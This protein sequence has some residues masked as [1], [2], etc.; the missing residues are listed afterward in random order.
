MPNNVT[1]IN[2]W[3]TSNEKHRLF[4]YSYFEKISDQWLGRALERCCYHFAS[5]F[6]PLQHQH[7]SRLTATGIFVHFIYAVNHLLQ[8]RPDCRGLI[9]VLAVVVRWQLRTA[10]GCSFHLLVNQLHIII[11]VVV[12]CDEVGEAVCP[13]S[14]PD[15]R[16]QMDLIF[17]HLGRTNVHQNCHHFSENQ[18]SWGN[19]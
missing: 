4:I 10:F 16:P 3:R 12:K 19:F 2:Q 13:E 1:L 17:R 15:L 18:L 9:F 14:L 7:C 5:H 8:S 6:T 11:D